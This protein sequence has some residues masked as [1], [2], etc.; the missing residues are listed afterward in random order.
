MTQR[1][2]PTL[3]FCS[4]PVP[5]ALVRDVDPAHEAVRK[6]THGCIRG[7]AGHAHMEPFSVL[8]CLPSSARLRPE[9]VGHIIQTRLLRS[10][11][12]PVNEARQDVQTFITALG[13]DVRLV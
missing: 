1:N 5:S 2:M 6:L 10:V 3:I 9:Q 7:L 11:A 8:R 13:V 12:L 4:P